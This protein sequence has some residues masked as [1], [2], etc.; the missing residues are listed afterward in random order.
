M[1]KR[2]PDLSVIAA[3]AAP[4]P[5]RRAALAHAAECARCREQLLDE[6]PTHLFALLALTEIEPG[7]LAEVSQGVADRIDAAASAR[8]KRWI[9][10]AGWAAAA[11]LAVC[12]V[13][14]LAVPFAPEPAIAQIEEKQPRAEVEVLAPSGVKQIVDLTV[15]E[16]QVVM[17]FDERVKL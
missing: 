6:D 12:I 14:V 4:E 7:V 17:I 9:A 1:T 3:E 16:S 8:P 2:C 11:V 15:G 10:G 13:R 5:A